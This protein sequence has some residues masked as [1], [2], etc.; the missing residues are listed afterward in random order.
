MASPLPLQ[1]TVQRPSTRALTTTLK[2]FLKDGASEIDYTTAEIARSFFEKMQS[3]CTSPSSRNLPAMHVTI[4]HINQSLS[5]KNM[6]LL[7]KKAYAMIEMYADE[8]SSKA[9]ILEELKKHMGPGGILT[10][11]VEINWKKAL[12]IAAIF[13]AVANHYDYNTLLCLLTAILPLAASVALQRPWFLTITLTNNN[14]DHLHEAI[15]SKNQAKIQE[16][17]AGGFPLAAVVDGIPPL[18]YAITL[19]DRDAVE[20][21]LK[22]KA[23]P[24]QLTQ[25]IPTIIKTYNQSAEILELM[26]H[27]NADPDAAVPNSEPSKGDCLL[28]FIIK[29]KNPRP[30]I[31]T[32]IQKIKLL[33]QYG[34][35]FE[36]ANAN[37][38]TPLHEACIMANFWAVKALLSEGASVDEK[39]LEIAKDNA[40]IL[41][42]LK[43]AEAMK[44]LKAKTSFF[45]KKI[46]D[47]QIL[48]PTFANMVSSVSEK[49]KNEAKS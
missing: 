44:I 41:A 18:A 15:R 30:D 33:K 48:L 3:L 14:L 2:S 23:D 20:L 40:D 25:G 13:F 6:Q 12:G 9:K 26:L 36:I 17:I 24:G 43:T 37:Q 19:G 28:H 4:Q 21:L 16:L 42:E 45:I 11:A 46:T 7:L 5:P 27:Y 29:Q 8:P 1:Q 39:A 32:N 35:N 49:K 22:N 47:P 34:A 10:T 31:P 38:E